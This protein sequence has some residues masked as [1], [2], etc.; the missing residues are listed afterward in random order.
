MPYVH[1]KIK[2]KVQQRS[3][4]DKSFRNSGTIRCGTITPILCDEVIPNSRV[5][6]KLNLASQLPPL[7]SDTYM[8]CKLRVEAFFTPSRLLCKSFEDFFCDF[9]R[10]VFDYGE[11]T[12][13]YTK[14]AIPYAAIRAVSGSSGYTDNT[15]FGPG[16]L[17]DY[18]GIRVR[19]LN[20]LRS[21]YFSLLPFINYHLV[22]QE[23]YRN[24]RVQR[25]AF[26]VPAGYNQ[27]VD[28]AGHSLPYMYFARNYVDGAALPNPLI[29][30]GAVTAFDA[31]TQTTL[32]DGSSLFDLRQRN[33]GV[34]YFT[35]ARVDAQ[36]GLKAS[37]SVDTL[38]DDTDGEGDTGFTI[39]ALRAANSLQ[40]FRERN[41]MPSP[42]LID[43]VKV[44][45]GANLS[46]GVAQRPI[47]IGSAEYNIGS[48]GVDQTAP[49][50]GD[51]QPKN[52][53]SGVA[54]QYGRAYASGSDFLISD[55]TANEPGFILVNLTLVPDTTYA[56]G[57]SP[58]FKRY[59]ADGSITD[60]ACHLLQNVG[61][62]PIMDDEITGYLSDKLKVFG[63]QDRFAD[64]MYI[65]NQSHGK[66]R[67]GQNLDSFVLQR[68]FGSNPALS[69]DF[70]EIPTNYLD[71]V[72]AVSSQVS[73]VGA[74]Y[75][76]LLEYKV[77]MPL[78][79]WSIPSLQDPAYEHGD[80]ISIHRNGQIF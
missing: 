2:V 75:D 36:Q 35:G 32:F 26:I 47:C 57:I 25:P 5:S 38:G 48:R 80:T 71:D 31:A 28:L 30:S 27:G 24:P 60:M 34:D 42:R 15:L 37:V 62:Q 53:F 22:W 58:I 14:A 41:N 61:D 3:G 29:L 4:F 73:G 11:D 7:V 45:Y 74:W 65:P 69:S 19:Q 77:S 21:L 55:F 18:L 70:L 10:Q 23:W 64:W 66:F 76:A 78:A 50:S 56:G 54:A 67:Y 40:Q 51:E 16:S 8:N 12:A 79:E 13:I 49:A 63:Y 46:D 59:L 68:E 43:Q 20:D 44:R 9:P 72:L 17:A 1:N 39:A 52:P 6:L 33:F